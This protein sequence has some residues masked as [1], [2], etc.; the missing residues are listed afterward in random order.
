MIISGVVFGYLAGVSYWFP[1]IFGFKLNEKLGK[2]AASCWIAGFIL[3]FT[4]LYILGL[5]GATRRMD[6]YDVSLGWQWLFIVAAVGVFVILLGVGF[7]VLQIVVSI[8][9]RHN[10]RDISGEVH[11]R[12]FI[13]LQSSQMHL[14]AMLF[15]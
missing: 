10:N 15:G 8:F 3:A 14:S 2:L 9:Q 11:L 5:M 12:Q 7:Q 1:K 6:H 4:P 13:T